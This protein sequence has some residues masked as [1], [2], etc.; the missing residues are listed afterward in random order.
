VAET[1]KELQKNPTPSTPGRSTQ[2]PSAAARNLRDVNIS[3][4]IYCDFFCPLRKPKFH[5]ARLDT[6]RHVRRV[7]RV[8][9]V[10]R[11]ESS[12]ACSNMADD[13]EADSA[14]LF[15]FSLL[16]SGFASISGTTSGKSQVHMST[17]VHA[18]ATPLYTCRA[19]CACR[20]TRFTPCCSTSA[21]RLATS[22]RFTSRF[23][24]MPKCMG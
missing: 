11:S 24:P 23:L 20:D 14:R 2:R 13:E 6:T 9:R 15:K 17:A 3:P 1:A 18:V 16:C 10:V 22:C 5:L 12:R 8:A 4:F 7:V 21:T 19:S